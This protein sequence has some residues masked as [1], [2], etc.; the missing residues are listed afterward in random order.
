MPVSVTLRDITRQ[1]WRECV[2]LK[3]RPD[4]QHFV[5]TNAGSMAQ[6]RYEPEWIP[7]AVYDGATMVGFVMYGIALD[8]RQHWIL[9]VMVDTAHQGKGY[10]RAAM[11]ALLTRMRA[12]PTC[13]E[14]FISY[15]P[16]N[17]VAEALYL[18]L[19]FE[20]TGAIVEGEVVARLAVRQREPS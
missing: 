10:G 5:A 15:E 13:D 6:A 19:G 11:R 9:R 3:V 4:Q 20:K 14:I 7:L 16:D 1:N 8:D 17:A 2:N 18:S 12:D